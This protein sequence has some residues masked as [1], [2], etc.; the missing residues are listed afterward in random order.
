MSVGHVICNYV[1]CISQPLLPDLAQDDPDFV[2]NDSAT[3]R[4]QC[5]VAT[6]AAQLITR[7]AFAPVWHVLSNACTE[8]VVPRVSL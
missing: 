8:L 3:T 5:F 2:I 7:D 1:T 4:R 6:V